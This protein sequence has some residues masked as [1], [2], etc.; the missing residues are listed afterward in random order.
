MN[1]KRSEL[2]NASVWLGVKVARSLR[3]APAQKAVVGWLDARISA[4]GW[5]GVVGGAVA[6]AVAVV[7]VKADENR[8][9]Y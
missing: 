2:R 5:V 7:L 9:R 3:S 4:R 8:L 1:A 6:V